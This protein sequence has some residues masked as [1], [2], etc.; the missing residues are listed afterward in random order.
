MR[1]LW[2]LTRIADLRPCP[3]RSLNGIPNKP[4]DKIVI[5]KRRDPDDPAG[6]Q[7][8]QLTDGERPA[9]PLGLR[10]A[11]DEPISGGRRRVGLT[12]LQKNS[13][14]RWA[15]LLKGLGHEPDR[16]LREEVMAEIACG[17]RR[18]NQGFDVA[19]LLREMVF[20]GLDGSLLDALDAPSVR[21]H[22]KQLRRQRH[23]T[24]DVDSA[25]DLDDCADAIRLSRKRGAQVRS[26][27][28]RTQDLSEYMVYLVLRKAFA[29]RT[30]S[31]LPK[32]DMIDQE[33]WLPLPNDRA[34]IET[35]QNRQIDA[36][37]T[38]RKVTRAGRLSPAQHVAL[39]FYEAKLGRPTNEQDLD[40]A[41]KTVNRLQRSF[42]LLFPHQRHKKSSKT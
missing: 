35:A 34:A 16:I 26:T 12:A 24:K 15:S 19:G 9:K 30:G 20:W 17:L 1:C 2:R 27:E 10:A 4:S 28:E 5:V 25:R 36:Y 18:Q 39:A 13:F 32:G 33:I 42:R 7:K 8:N 29:E 38:T 11:S 40:E 41:V 14:L 6:G 37:T 23:D 3:R 22:L 21:A 31:R